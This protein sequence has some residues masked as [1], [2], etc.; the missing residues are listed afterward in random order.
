M[1]L[2]IKLKTLL[3]AGLVVATLAAGTAAAYLTTRGGRQDSPRQPNAVAQRDERPDGPLPLKPEALAKW[4]GAEVIVVAKLQSVVAGPVGLSEPPLYTHT[5]KLVADRS[6]RGQFKAGDAISG[7]HQVRQKDRPIFPE[8]KDC[9]VALK[10]VRGMWQV[11]AIVEATR[12]AVDEAESV[13]RVPLGWTLQKDRL[14]S[15]WAGMGQQAWPAGVKPQTRLFCSVTGRPALLVGPGIEMTAEPVKPKVEVKFANP[16]GDGEYR[17][18]LKNTTDRAITIP[19]LLSVDGQVLWNESL[20]ILCQ[21]KVYS[22]PGAQGVKK[23]PTATTLKA[24]ES[25][26]T[27]VNALAL[28]GPEWPR[29]GYRIEFQFALGEKSATHSFY[30]LSRHHDPI[31]QKLQ[32]GKKD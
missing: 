6:L 18:T 29:G 4:G 7:S 27:V 32:G 24:G 5:L 22:L 20:V 13:S 25:I 1:L 14:V 30:Y 8:G 2:W 11:V 23:M 26:S 31:R 10:Q 12:A 21:G 19:A 16:D 28:Q 3:A 17:I 9:V 15:P